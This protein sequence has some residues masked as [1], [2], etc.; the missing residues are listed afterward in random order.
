M[1]DPAIPPVVPIRPAANYAW[2][3]MMLI[4]AI[5]LIVYGY[6]RYKDVP[7]GGTVTSIRLT[8]KADLS[9][10]VRD[11]YAGVSPTT[12][13]FYLKL[14]LPDGSELKLQPFDDTPLGNGLTW[15]L[16]KPIPLD[17]IARVEVWDDN[18]MLP[19]KQLDRIEIPMSAWEIDGQTFHLRMNGSKLEPPRWATPLIG[20]GAMLFA[21]VLLRFVWDQ[22]I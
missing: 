12:A 16:D 14:F 15:T 1:S 18:S 10:Q 4:P 9:G 3:L 8:S 2:R 6:W 17:Q 22:A 13:D 19:D 21:V 11:A 20:V 5:A 7:P